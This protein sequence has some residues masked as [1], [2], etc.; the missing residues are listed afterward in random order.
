MQLVLS[1][2]IQLC[3]REALEAALQ[4]LHW[5]DM[6]DLTA[7]Q[8]KLVAN[9][10]PNSSI[11]RLTRDMSMRTPGTIEVISQILEDSQKRISDFDFCMSIL[12][13]DL[14]W[15]QVITHF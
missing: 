6:S 13:W 9:A 15:P 10:L 4:K 12:I 3:L 1:V 7:E 5:F 14:L 8:L 11:T 2:D